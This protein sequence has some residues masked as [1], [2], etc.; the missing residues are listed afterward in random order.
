MEQLALTGGSPTNR[1][2]FP[3]WPVFGDAEKEGLIRVLESGKWGSTKGGEVR[4]FERCFADFH[5]AKYGIATNAIE[6]DLLARIEE[7]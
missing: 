6:Y 7:Q 5:N 2:P 1:K 4:A 3:A